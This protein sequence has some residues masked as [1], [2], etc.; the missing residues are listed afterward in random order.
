MDAATRRQPRTPILLA[1]NSRQEHPCLATAKV[2]NSLRTG[3][4]TSVGRSPIIQP[5]RRGNQGRFEM[6]PQAA[7]A[8]GR[9][10]R[11]R[12]DGSI[13]RSAPLGAAAP[14][15][16]A[17]LRPLPQALVKPPSK[18]DAERWLAEV[19]HAKTRGLWTDPRL[20]R[21]RFTDWVAAW[22]STT[23]NLRPTTRARDEA[24]LRLHALPRFG[25]LPLPRSTSLRFGRGSPSCLPRV[26]HPPRS[27]RP[28]SFSARSWPP[29]WT[30][31]TWRRAHVAMCHHPRVTTVPADRKILRPSI[32]KINL[33]FWG[34]KG[35]YA[36]STSLL[37]QLRQ[38][39][40]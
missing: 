12:A 3:R 2:A 32:R 17:D 16:C 1:L 9:Q 33:L 39:I 36:D 23:T 30:L 26:L 15:L 31:A 6:P 21:I 4:L 29:R 18:A 40:E 25:D 27:S 14:R 38:P 7:R 13:A 22:W 5:T 11:G 20:G 19:E 8:A 37:G 34:I 35:G 10:D 28:T 24:I